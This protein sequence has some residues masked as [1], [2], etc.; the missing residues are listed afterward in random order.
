VGDISHGRI[1]T[2]TPRKLARLNRRFDPA[3]MSTTDPGDR[4]KK[5]SSDPLV[6]LHYQ[7]SLA[8]AA[9]EIETIV[10]ADPSGV[11]VAGAGSWAACA[12]LAAYA[13][14]LAF[15]GARHRDPSSAQSRVDEMRS[16]V[17]V[18]SVD[19]DGSNVLLCLRGGNETV[20][21]QADFIAASVRRILRAA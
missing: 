10:L 12:E 1:V 15:D 6:A 18:R 9:G 11:V 20:T 5:R 13:P 3:H 19:V 14:L 16:E 17:T 2:T 8:R 7:L 21:V 4:R